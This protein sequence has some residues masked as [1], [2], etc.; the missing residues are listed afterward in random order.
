MILTPAE[1]NAQMA[2]FGRHIGAQVPV[3]A[4][5]RLPRREAWTVPDLFPEAQDRRQADAGLIAE[6]RAELAMF[7]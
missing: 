7:L 4:A 1:I 6:W 5:V 2:R 3:P